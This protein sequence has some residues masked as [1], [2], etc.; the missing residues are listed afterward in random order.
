M[1]QIKQVY[2]AL[3]GH[4][5]AMHGG[6]STLKAM[7]EQVGATRA[8]LGA[9]FIGDTGMS[10]QTW[11]AQWE[12]ALDQTVNAYS[13]MASTHE[14]NTV[15]MMGRDAAEGAKWGGAPV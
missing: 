5:E 2:P 3:L 9:A 10:V 11:L 1:S 14:D 7:G 15:S 4:A 6:A 12:A 8:T 13:Q